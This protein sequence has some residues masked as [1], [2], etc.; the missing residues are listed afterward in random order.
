MKTIADVI[1]DFRSAF[2]TILYAANVSGT[3]QDVKVI[4][5]TSINAEHRTIQQSFTRDMLIPMIEAVASL[6]TDLRNEASVNLCKKLMDVI[7]AEN[8]LPYI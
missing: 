2:K 5:T 1:A 8:P 3:R 4:I 6:D 7:N